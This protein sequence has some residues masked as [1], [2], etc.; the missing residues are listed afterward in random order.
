MVYTTEQY[1]LDRQ[2]IED[3]I[4]K[5]WMFLDLKLSTTDFVSRCVNEVFASRIHVDYT[6]LF[7]HGEPQDISAREQAEQWSVLLGKM[8]GCL[9]HT[10]A[11]LPDLPVPDGKIGLPDTTTVHT[12][13]ITVMRRGE[14][15]A[16]NGCVLELVLR[17]IADLKGNGWRIVSTKVITKA[18]DIGDAQGVFAP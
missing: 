17:R 5:L 1:L 3:T 2:L 7:G 12:K 6:V 8:D 14:C 10:G 16:Q 15:V 11:V 4:H 9:H 18:F 13:A